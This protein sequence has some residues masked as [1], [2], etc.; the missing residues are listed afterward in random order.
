MKLLKTKEKEIV[1]GAIVAMPVTFTHPLDYDKELLIQAATH[2][3]L[4]HV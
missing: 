2:P 3:T 1:S 4:R